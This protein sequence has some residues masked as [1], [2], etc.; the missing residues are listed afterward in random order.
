MRHHRVAGGGGTQLH[1]V[2]SGDP[3]GPPILFLH[4]WSQAHASW[5]RQLNAAALQSFRLIACDLRG[6]G[7]SDKPLDGYGESALWAADV[8]AILSALALDRPVLV[9]WSYAGYV[10]ADYVRAHGDGAL[11]GIVFVGAATDTGR[12]SYAPPGDG[13][14][15]IL[16]DGT[17]NPNIYSPGA[18]EA[19]L[20]MRQFMRAC[21]AA[22]VDHLTELELLGIALSTPPRVREAL[23]ARR[24]A[25]DDVLQAIRVPVL[26][27]HGERDRIVDV[28]TARHIAAQIPQATLSLY[29]QAGHAP[30]WEAQERFN[31]ELA[32]FA[33]PA[34]A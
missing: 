33:Q 30:F 11:R 21:F 16:P 2:E 17:G 10:I 24:L 27:A 12:T 25:N 18:E 26:I 5:Q 32:A 8:A 13:W 31:A 29:P 7:D 9:G 14:A 1:V 20:A 3:A 6:H 22:P 28:A 19:A 34:R 15:G 4:G 23:F